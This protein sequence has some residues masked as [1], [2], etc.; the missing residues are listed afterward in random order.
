MKEGLSRKFFDYGVLTSIR[1]NPRLHIFNVHK[2]TPTRLDS[3]IEDILNRLGEIF[4]KKA[5]DINLNGYHWLEWIF[6][7]HHP[8]AQ[9]F[10][11]NADAITHHATH[12]GIGAAPLRIYVAEFQNLEA[13]V[14]A[15]R[16]IRELVGV[17]NYSVHATDTHEEAVALAQIYFNEN[18]LHFVNNT[19]IMSS[20]WGKRALNSIHEFK[21]HVLA[22]TQDS[23]NVL[24]DGSFP[25]ALYG[26]RDAMDIDYLSDNADTAHSIDN[27][28]YDNHVGQLR[29]HIH[30]TADLVFDP[31][32]HFF[33][34]G[35][36]IVSLPA[37]LHMK[38]RRGENKDFADIALISYIFK[39]TLIDRLRVAY[40]KIKMHLLYKYLYM[41]FPVG[42]RRRKWAKQ[43][44]GVLRNSKKQLLTILKRLQDIGPTHRTTQ[45][46]GFTLHYSRGTSIVQR[47]LQTG[48]YEPA[49]VAALAKIIHEDT[50]PPVII[51]AGA[52]I[53]MISLAILQKHP[54]AII[55]AFEP[56]PHQRELFEKTIADNM[57][58]H[59]ISLYPL[60]LS[61][62]EGT[63]NFVT[64]NT[65]HVSGDGLRDTGR[66]GPATTCQVSAGKLDS[67]W[68][69]T[70]V[71]NITLI[72]MDIEGAELLALRGATAVLQ[73]CRPVV[74]F[75]AHATNLRAYDL[76]IHDLLGFWAGL[77][78]KTA[79]LD[80]S[81]VT[82]NQLKHFSTPTYGC[83]LIA[84]PE[85]WPFRK[86]L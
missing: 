32:N 11:E 13:A 56:G 64:H 55:H 44:K 31:E 60:A 80:G 82:Q 79:N 72:K 62:Q 77:K 39:K 57:L 6:Y 36:K 5:L 8:W 59:S 19:K 16:K 73:A 33:C 58:T 86:S 70:A 51:D 20:A 83:N 1:E 15:K 29:F 63:V 18:T 38:T 42:S 50:R 65:Q 2:V 61:D 30:S 40:A 76:S 67:W 52:N 21:V 34:E 81:P 37:L 43:C 17:G 69:K 68:V 3:V 24:I 10:V 41:I 47:F 35:M 71:P 26:L 23:D 49:E 45:Y 4:C 66:A 7:R 54:N 9:C 74:L 46:C 75:E 28:I 53:G 22:N 27:R 85:G 25:L 48:A 78:Y 14:Q 12:S 84:Y